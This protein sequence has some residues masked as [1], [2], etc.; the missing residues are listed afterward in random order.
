M[1]LSDCLEIMRLQLKLRLKFNDIDAYNRYLRS[2]G[3]R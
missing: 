1:T 2:V 3:E